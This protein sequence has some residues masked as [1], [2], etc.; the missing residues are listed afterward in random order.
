MT[1]NDGTK[2]AAGPP[3]VV[4]P[5]HVAAAAQEGAA[6]KRAASPKPMWVDR[7]A[8]SSL[9]KA[10]VVILATLFFLSLAWKA[11]TLLRML[12]VSLF[13]ALAMIPAVQW[14]HNRWGWKRGAAVG[15]IYGAMV[16]F[17]VLMVVVLIP[18]ISSFAGQINTDSGSMADKINGYSQNLVGQDVIAQSTATDA[19]ATAGTGLT[20]WAQDLAGVATTGLGFVFNMMTVLLFTFYFAADAPRI[21]NALMARM[22]AHKQKVNGWIWD[23]AIEQTARGSI[24]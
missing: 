1:S 20:S 19:G 24:V 14:R 16:L 15:A 8:W 13:F 10:V 5:D 7:F 17:L 22:P 2:G 9:W 23:T 4:V 6:V 18:A 3:D 11:Q 12:G 21:Q